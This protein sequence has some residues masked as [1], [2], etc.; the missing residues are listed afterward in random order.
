[1]KGGAGPDGKSDDRFTNDVSLSPRTKE[2]KLFV[3]VLC[4]VFACCWREFGTAKVCVRVRM[5]KKQ[6]PQ[7]GPGHDV[8]ATW[9]VSRRMDP[10]DQQ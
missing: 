2:Q 10:A 4:C 1:M 8:T 7:D 5:K 3:G 9:I 6:F